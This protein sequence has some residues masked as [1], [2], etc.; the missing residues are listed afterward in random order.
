[1]RRRLR[2]LDVSDADVAEA[3]E[4]IQ[5]AIKGMLHRQRMSVGDE[6]A[7]DH[8]ATPDEGDIADVIQGSGTS[9]LSMSSRSAQGSSNTKEQGRQGDAGSAEEA[10]D[11]RG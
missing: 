10:E 9:M 7:E 1:M 8:V 3:A 11:S 5:G 2:Q 6:D 4:K